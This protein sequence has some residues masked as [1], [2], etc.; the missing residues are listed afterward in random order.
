MPPALWV[1]SM[2][3]IRKVINSTS[4]SKP[5]VKPIVND[6]AYSKLIVNDAGYS[7]PMTLVTAN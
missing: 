6:T 5:I 1:V 3:L 7:K 2:F 4:Y